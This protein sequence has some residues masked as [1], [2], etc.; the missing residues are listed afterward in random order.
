MSNPANCVGGGGRKG[1]NQKQQMVN[2]HSKDM[3]VD[4]QQSVDGGENNPSTSAAATLEECQADAA[5]NAIKK[6]VV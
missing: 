5:V 4:D 3:S 1:P 6:W 2:R